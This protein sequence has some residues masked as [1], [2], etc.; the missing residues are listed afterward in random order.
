MAKDVEQF[1]KCISTI[2][3]CSAESFVLNIYPIF[4]LSFWYFD[5][6]EEDLSQHWCLVSLMHGDRYESICILLQ[7]SIQLHQHYLLKM[8]SFFSIL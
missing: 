3:E 1:F 8:L 2:W 6:L 5:V 4:K 7:V